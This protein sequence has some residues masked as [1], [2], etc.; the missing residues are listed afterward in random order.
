MSCQEEGK[1][2]AFLFFRDLSNLVFHLWF[3]MGNLQQPY[4]VIVTTGKAGIS[5]S[6]IEPVSGVTCCWTTQKRVAH[7]IYCVIVI[8]YLIFYFLYFPTVICC[9]SCNLQLNYTSVV[10]PTGRKLPTVYTS[11]GKKVFSGTKRKQSWFS[12]LSAS[13]FFLSTEDG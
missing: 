9:N 5:Q 8:C 6:F 13:S 1:R 2:V 3:S 11:T 4:S 12:N 10:R 7:S